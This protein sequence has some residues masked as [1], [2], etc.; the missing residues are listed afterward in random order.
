[1][2]EQIRGIK[3][4]F[5]NQTAT[6]PDRIILQDTRAGQRCYATVL[7]DKLKLDLEG[8]HESLQNKTRDRQSGA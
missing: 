6:A 3:A 7:G 5:A 8:A 1:M 4:E 2:C